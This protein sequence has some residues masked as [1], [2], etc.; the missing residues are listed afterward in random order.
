MSSYSDAAD[1]NV[2][3]R[4]RKAARR[5]K[6]SGEHHPRDY[7][8][9][10][11]TCVRKSIIQNCAINDNEAIQEKKRG[12]EKSFPNSVASLLNTGGL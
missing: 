9:Y 5:I 7:L 10:P 11:Q 2:R 8:Q 4:S 6:M 12:L 3:S 1:A